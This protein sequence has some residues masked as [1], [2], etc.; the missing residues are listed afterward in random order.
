MCHPSSHDYHG[1]EPPRSRAEAKERVAH[2]KV[3]YMSLQSW[4]QCILYLYS[5]LVAD[6]DSHSSR[7]LYVCPDSFQGVSG[8]YIFK[9]DVVP[10]HGL[11]GMCQ[12]DILL[13]S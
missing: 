8:Q 13:C 11:V 12:R 1:Q 6:S 5:I 7:G 4:C 10:A 3:Y 2:E 9:L